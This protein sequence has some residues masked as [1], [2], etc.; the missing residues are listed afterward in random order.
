MNL[1]ETVH[2]PASNKITEYIRCNLCSSDNTEPWAQKGTHFFVKCRT[3]GLI[4]RNPRIRDI[5]TKEI[6]YDE[7]Y[8]F[9]EEAVSPFIQNARAKCYALERRILEGLTTRRTILDVGGGVGH[10]MNSFGPQWDR[11]VIDISSFGIEHAKRKYGLKGVAGE[12]E[13]NSFHDESFD[14]VYIRGALHHTFDPMKCINEAYRVLRPGGIVAIAMD[15]DAGG[16]AGTVFKEHLRTINLE[17]Y[18]FIFT[19][20]IYC[21]YLRQSKFRIIK[22]CHAYFGS[23]YDTLQDWFNFVVDAFTF[24]CIRPIV[25]QFHNKSAFEEFKSRTFYDNLVSVYGIKE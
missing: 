15:V 24:R 10:F 16:I 4:Y 6:K 1:N 25:K 3:C 9:S 7:N 19:K 12:F 2:S 21:D 22:S 8:F 17:L 18:N 14:I 5:S 11:T 23:G 20:K 13:N